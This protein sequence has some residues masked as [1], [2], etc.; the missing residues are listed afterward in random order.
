MLKLNKQGGFS[1][2]ELMIS[3]FL[4][5]VLLAMLIGLYV[6]GV[7]NSAKS[8]KYSRLRTDLQSMLTIIESDIRR[9]GYGGE[10]YLVGAANDKSVDTLTRN[11]SPPLNCVVLS[12]DTALYG[13]VTRKGFLH[14]FSDSTIQYG[15]GLSSAA[16][17]CYTSVSWENMSDP[18][19]LKITHFK[20]TEKV[21]SSATATI[22]NVD[23]GLT[24]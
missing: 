6:A 1:L 24:G 20:F 17:N 11:G 14:H 8:L 7:S 3:L 4:G 13:S 10:D 21:T 9:A 23:I 19:F 22:R 12:Y 2:I 5:S 18:N 15:S 16:L